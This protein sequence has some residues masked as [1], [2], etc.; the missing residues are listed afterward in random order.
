MASAAFSLEAEAVA[1]SHPQSICHASV[2]RI[3]SRP[4]MFPLAAAGAFR[5]DRI[6]QSFPKSVREYFAS[7][8][9]VGMRGCLQAPLET[10]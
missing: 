10:R 6:D 1:G 7:R 3:A 5:N 9:Q 4:A 2:P 8:L